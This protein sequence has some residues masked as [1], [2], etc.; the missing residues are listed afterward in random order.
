MKLSGALLA[1][2]ALS[3]GNMMGASLTF[4]A[5][6]GSQTTTVNFDGRVGG[7]NNIIA[8]LS[9]A[10]VFSLI[11][12]TNSGKAWNFEVKVYETGSVDARVAGLAFVNIIPDL[13]SGPN[14]LSGSVTN[15]GTTQWNFVVDNAMNAN[16]FGT[17]EACLLDQNN[18]CNGGGNGGVANGSNATVL[19]TLNF[20]QAQTQVEFRGLGVRYQSIEGVT[21]GTSGT[22][23]DTD[24]NVPGNEPGGVPEPSTVALI[25]LGLT[26]LAVASRRRK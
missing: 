15:P 21:A 4:A 17:I 10:A 19:F 12:V 18:N 16:N 13:Q 2:L 26:G 9:S 14:L 11:D 7:P 6:G 5:N 24:V 22:G 3:V 23:R 1:L 20:S 25:G 8:G